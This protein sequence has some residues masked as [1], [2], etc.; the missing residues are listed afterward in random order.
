LASYLSVSGALVAL[1]DYLELHMAVGLADVVDNPKA[2]VLGSQD[3]KGD[4]GTTNSIGIYLHRISV[5]PYGRNRYLKPS[6]PDRP[7]R[8]ELPVNLHI[9]LIGWS[10]T[11]TA[12]THLV[13]WG[14]QHIGSALELDISHLGL[15]DPGWG[16]QDSIQVIPEEMSTEDLMRV[17]DSLPGDYR[18]SSPYILKTLRLEPTSPVTQGPPVRTIVLPVEVD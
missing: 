13:A 10:P 15:S 2:Q 3:L 7:A 4:P 5:D 18:L 12:E 8:P 9:L 1:K 11:A 6:S 16:E 17:W 14:M